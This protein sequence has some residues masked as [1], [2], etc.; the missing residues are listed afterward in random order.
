MSID[1]KLVQDLASKQHLFE[2]A[3]VG[4]KQDYDAKCKGYDAKCDDEA[5]AREAYEAEKSKNLVLKTL[6]E[7]KDQQLGKSSKVIDYLDFEVKTLGQENVGL[8]SQNVDLKLQLGEGIMQN[9]L[10]AEA[11]DEFEEIAHYVYDLKSGQLQKLQ[12]AYDSA[13]AALRNYVGSEREFAALKLHADNIGKQKAALE[14]ALDKVIEQRDIAVAQRDYG[15]KVAGAVIAEKDARYDYFAKTANSVIAEKDDELDIVRE[16]YV[17]KSR[18]CSN[19]EA[20]RDKTIELL[21]KTNDELAPL[22]AVEAER[23]SKEQLVEAF[24]K[25]YKSYTSGSDADFEHCARSAVKAV[26]DNG[27]DGG[28]VL[29][30]IR[31]LATGSTKEKGWFGRLFGSSSPIFDIAGVLECIL[32]NA[33]AEDV[34]G[35]IDNICSLKNSGFSN[36]WIAGM[37]AR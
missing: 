5:I 25:E 19:A 4:M 36:V 21:C 23:L 6:C 37:Y 33:G 11:R 34:S 26:E 16:A 32:E 29:S 31:A 28:K 10:L 27:L 7:S 35:V 18:Q 30:L 12:D 1:L 14:S 17:A 22:K 2:K 9:S 13:T 3:F 15:V 8:T 24:K 20:G